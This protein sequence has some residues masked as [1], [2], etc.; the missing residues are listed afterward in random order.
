MN[1]RKGRGRPPNSASPA[2]RKRDSAIAETVSAMYMWGFPRDVVLKAVSSAA[3]VEYQKR[4]APQ[5]RVLRLL[6]KDAIKAIWERASNSY[7]TG[8]PPRVSRFRLAVR[9]SQ[10]AHEASS[11]TP[12]EIAARFLANGGEWTTPEPAGSPMGYV[13]SDDWFAN[14]LTPT[15]RKNYRPFPLNY[16]PPKQEDETG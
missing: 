14:A 15:A 7:G 2:L 4:Q 16:V 12:V 10:Q 13:R 11:M 5:S 8:K 9:H 6:G 1:A 3:T